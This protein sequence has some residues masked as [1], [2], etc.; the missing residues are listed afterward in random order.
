MT[1]P[2]NTQTH[3]ISNYRVPNFHTEIRM[4][5]TNQMVVTPVRG[6]GRSEGVFPMER[7]LDIACQR[8]G[9]DTNR[10]SSEE[11]TQGR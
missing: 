2:L 4:V 8:T 9:Y 3:T 6:A 1:V 10:D 5:F 7:M 11:P